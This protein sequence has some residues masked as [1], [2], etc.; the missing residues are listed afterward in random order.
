MVSRGGW[1]KVGWDGW[2]PTRGDWATGSAAL[3]S[4]GEGKEAA[5]GRSQNGGLRLSMNGRGL[6]AGGP[7]LRSLYIK[8]GWEGVRF[9][10]SG[11][12]KELGFGGNPCGFWVAGRGGVGDRG[13]AVADGEAGNP[14]SLL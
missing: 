8:G 4:V 9:W 11:I 3:G 5:G 7:K 2:E 10:N 14:A 1:T 6:G 12:N 13:G